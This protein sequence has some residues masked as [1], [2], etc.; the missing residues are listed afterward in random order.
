MKYFLGFVIGSTA[1]SMMLNP[2]R[3]RAFKAGY[4]AEKARLASSKK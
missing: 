1:M 2:A 3:K 4:D